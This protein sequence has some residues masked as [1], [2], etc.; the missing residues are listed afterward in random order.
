VCLTSNVQTRAVSDFKNHPLKFYFDFGI[1]VTINTDNRL[2]TD[3]T[4]TTELERAVNTF[5]LDVWQVRQLILNGFKSAFLPFHERQSLLRRTSEQLDHLID[6]ELR[7]QGHV[8]PVPTQTLT[9]GSKRSLV[10][11]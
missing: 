11:V 5:D 6:D 2:I 8:V 10:A 1:R 4:V 3:T 7:A 9:D